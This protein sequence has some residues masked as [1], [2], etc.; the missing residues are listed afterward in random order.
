MNGLL[1]LL[2]FNSKLVRLKVVDDLLELDEPELMFQ[3][4]T[5]AIK[6]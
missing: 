4:Q 3:F 5:G 1:G 2:G 6:S